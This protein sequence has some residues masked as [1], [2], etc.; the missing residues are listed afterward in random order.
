MGEGPQCD[1]RERCRRCCSC[2]SRRLISVVTV[3]LDRP[4]RLQSLPFA[5]CH[6]LDLR[7]RPVEGARKPRHVRSNR[8]DHRQRGARQPQGEHLEAMDNGKHRVRSSATVR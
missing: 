3:D 7:P 5:R 6:L 1:W 4:Q 8:H 2:V